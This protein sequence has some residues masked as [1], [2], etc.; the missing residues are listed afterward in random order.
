MNM[1]G[2]GGSVEVPDVVPAAVGL[3]IS[4]EAG[5]VLVEEDGALD[6]LEAR[7][8]PLE[9]GRHAQD[10]LVGDLTAAADAE[11]Q[12]P[13]PHHPAALLSYSDPITKEKLVVLRRGSRFHGNPGSRGH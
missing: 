1:A 4:D 5:A 2:G 11:A 9:I 10:V 3:A 12:A 13:A 6:A 8:V 7:G